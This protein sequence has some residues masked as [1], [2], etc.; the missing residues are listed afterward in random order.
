M[1]SQAKTGLILSI[2][3]IIL[4]FILILLIIV[5]VVISDMTYSGF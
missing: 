1:D 4:T 5:L 2:I 3:G